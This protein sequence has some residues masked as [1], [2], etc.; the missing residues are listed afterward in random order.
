MDI[1]LN[2]LSKRYKYEWIF[3]S[4]DYRFESG[5]Q[6][7]ISGPN[8]SGKSTLLKILSGH[9]SPSKGEIVFSLNG[10]PLEKDHVFRYV[11]YAAPYVDLI[12]EFTLSEMLRF[13]G[14]FKPFFQGLTS[15]ELIDILQFS[16]SKSK[17]VAYFSSG[18]KQRLKLVLALCSDTPLLLL[19]EP[20][21]NL[22]AQGVDWYRELIQV[23]GQNRTL[24]IASNIHHDFDFCEGRLNILDFKRRK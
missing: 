24:I 1:S 9:L 20:T 12:E 6:Y 23:Y 22:D 14:K 2:N 13:H 7:A 15:T 10:E 3:R 4:I 8:G 19:D 16:K 17:E 11:A 5:K 18:M 21:T